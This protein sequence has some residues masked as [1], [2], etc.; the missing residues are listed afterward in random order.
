[1][2]YTHIHPRQDVVHSTTESPSVQE[3]YFASLVLWM[4]LATLSF[5]CI[6]AFVIYF[7]VLCCG[8]RDKESERRSRKLMQIVYLPHV[9]KILPK[10]TTTLSP[11]MK[12]TKVEV[13]PKSP[14][15][16]RNKISVTTS[17]V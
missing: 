10:P 4:I 14:K 11:T 6:V 9:Y 8:T 3:A 2:A 16:K 7:S 15:S 13:H 1:M 5:S 12:S 17:L